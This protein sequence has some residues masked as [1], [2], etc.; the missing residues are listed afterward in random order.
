MKEGPAGT[1]ARDRSRLSFKSSA[2]LGAVI[3]WVRASML[4]R[5]LQHPH[6]LP[7]HL[8]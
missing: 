3:L 7:A 4:V 1:N 8:W 6:T 2:S 5:V